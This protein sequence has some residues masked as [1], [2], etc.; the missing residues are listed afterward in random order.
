MA[1]FAQLFFDSINTVLFDS[2]YGEYGCAILFFYTNNVVDNQLSVHNETLSR[3]VTEEYDA[4]IT[5]NLKVSAMLVSNNSTRELFDINKPISPD[6][7]LRLYRNY[8]TVQQY[9]TQFYNSNSKSSIYFYIKDCNF[10]VG[11]YK[12]NTFVMKPQDAFYT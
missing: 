12:N 6:E 11:D 4:I 9:Y 10:I 3:F 8:N 1:V 5:E 2:F 7:R